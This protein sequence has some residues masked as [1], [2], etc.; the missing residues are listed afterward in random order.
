MGL[1]QHSI[2]RA[3]F[4]IG[5]Q[6]LH[7][8]ES[9]VPSLTLKW[10]LLCYFVYRS[11]LLKTV[12]YRDQ[13]IYFLYLWQC[14]PS[15]QICMGN[16]ETQGIFEFLSKHKMLLRVQADRL[17]QRVKTCMYKHDNHIHLENTHS[18][19]YRKETTLSYLQNTQMQKRMWTTT[20]LPLSPTHTNIHQPVSFRG[21]LLF[22]RRTH[23]VSHNYAL[24]PQPFTLK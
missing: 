15:V 19:T 3:Y 13:R 10:W 18:E 9:Y 5:H 17:V 23:D 6:A 1:F 24:V 21:V 8:K 14:C 12:T 22:P 2:I 11:S 20:F 16:R 7:I 4:S